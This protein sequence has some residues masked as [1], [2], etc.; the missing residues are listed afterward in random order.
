MRFQRSVE[1][2]KFDCRFGCNFKEIFED[3]ISTQSSENNRG[4]PI[5][6]L[7]GGK[8]K[9]VSSS[10]AVEQILLLYTG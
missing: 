3:W 4:L 2:L 5:Q 1:F 9:Y 8:K 7:V 6:F 10:S